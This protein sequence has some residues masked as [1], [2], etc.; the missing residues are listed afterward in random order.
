MWWEDSGVPTDTIT[1]ERRALGP[2]RALR[3]RN[4]SLLFWGQLISSTGTQM[5]VVAVAWQ[6]YLLTHSALAL[7]LIGLFQAIPR[8]LFSLIGG[9]LAD[10]FDRRK[11]LVVVNLSLMVFSIVLAICTSAKIIT[12][13]M[14]YV[15]ILLSAAVSS[16]E[17]PTRQAMVPTLVPRAQMADALS[18]SSVMMQFT[19]ILGPTA[20]G[21]VLAWLG[22]AN[23]Y[24]FDVVSY[25][26]VIGSLFLMIVP[27]VPVE[28]RARVGLGALF[29]GMRF[30]KA[31]PIIL[32]VLSL[33]FCANFFG[34]PRALLPIYAQNIMHVGPQGL[35]LLLAATSIGAVALAPFTGVVARVRRQGLL[36]ALAIVVWGL[37]ITA[38]GFFPNPLWLGVLFLAGSGAADMVSSILR[39]LVLQLTTPD[40]F[41]G[42]V[43]SV[44]AMFG[45]G[46]PL[47]GQV[48][49]GLVGGFFTP[50]ISVVSGGL[51]CIVAVLIIVALFPALTKGK[52]T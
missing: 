45:I 36:V 27:P 12:I 38:F 48:E 23:T 11:T 29:D 32:A 37:C 2:W 42:R 4:Y 26:V 34:S 43:S 10:V 5:Q 41:R 13:G 9:V 35:G 33:D 24:W 3:H 28:K 22:I 17:F 50:L 40:E 31:H 30:V 20:G 46:G 44:D 8:L 39:G 25:L 18:L 52:T 16:F 6:V 47:L 51:A 21:L 1:G 49:S 19:L 14:I 7:G 15:I